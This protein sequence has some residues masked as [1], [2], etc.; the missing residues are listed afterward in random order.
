MVRNGRASAHCV[1]ALFYVNVDTPE[2]DFHAVLEPTIVTSG[3]IPAPRETIFV[4]HA[5]PE[6]NEF[7]LWVSSKLAMAGYRVWVDRRRLRGGDDFWDEIDRVLRHESI[8][9]V[10]VFTKAAG[11]PGVKKELA[12]GEVMKSRLSDPKFMIPIRA[13]AIAFSDA[14]PEFLRGNI[15]DA[16]PN[17]HDCLKD[18]FETLEGTVVPKSASPD[19]AV[20][21]SI[22]EAREDGRR[23]VLDR[24]EDALTNWFP[25]T[26]PRA[27]RY[28]KFEGLQ[29][30]MRSWLNDCS[31]PVVPMGRLAGSF[32]DPIAFS[33]ASS[34][35]Q[36]IETAYD[37]PFSDFVGA[38][39]LGPYEERSAASNDVNNLLRQHFAAIAKTRGLKPIEFASGENGWY[40]PDDLIPANRITLTAPGGRRIR[41][42]MSGKF[43]KLRWHMCLQAKPRIWPSLVFRIRGNVVLS[44]NGVILSGEKTH[45]RRRRLT[46]SWWNDVWRDRLLAAVHFLADGEAEVCME[47]G[48]VR[49]VMAAWPLTAQLPVSYEATDPPL[50]TEEDEEGNIVPTAALDNHLDDLEGEDE[51]EDDGEGDS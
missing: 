18:L 23:F 4:T 20:L 8:K 41:R 43:K 31:V 24:P 25:I 17:W 11:K 28:F 42:T 46:R 21:R 38:K 7:A 19:A 34:F 29:D 44:E 32:C 13:D 26:P 15:L 37:L 3:P 48:N 36:Q 2:S 50:P 14:P 5:A 16:Y 35:D 10:V 39:N 47:A 49:F 30:H 1:F 45:K 27:I 12:I 40:F 6:D 22:V 9:Q 51:P 33:A